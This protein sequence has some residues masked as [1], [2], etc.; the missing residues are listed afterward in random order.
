VPDNESPV[1]TVLVDLDLG[2]SFVYPSDQVYDGNGAKMEG[3]DAQDVIDSMKESGSKYSAIADWA[4]LEWDDVE[5][6]VTVIR[7]DGSR[8]YAQW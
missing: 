5:I 8:T 6:N 4:L 1:K 7:E 3:Y 2:G